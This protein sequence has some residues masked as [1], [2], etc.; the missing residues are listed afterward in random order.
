MPLG[1]LADFLGNIWQW[2]TLVMAAD[3]FDIAKA[4]DSADDH[5]DMFTGG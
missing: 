1:R 2:A 3:S 4:R 5:G